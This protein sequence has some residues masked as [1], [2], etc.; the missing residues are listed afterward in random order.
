MTGST[1]LRDRDTHPDPDADEVAG[2]GPAGIPW[3]RGAVRQLLV[4]PVLVALLA[5]GAAALVVSMTSHTYAA[6]TKLLIDPSRGR[7]LTGYEDAVLSRIT[8]SQASVLESSVVL[9]PAA[10]KL[11]VAPPTLEAATSVQA[12]A[13][14]QVV[15]VTTTGHDAGAA[16]A[17]RNAVV[18]SYLKY[19]F[20]SDDPGIPTATE[21]APA[22]PAH[23]TRLAVTLRVA[24]A[25]AVLAGVATFAV[26]AVRRKVVWVP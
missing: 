26:M 18:D 5:G 21:I 20:E 7:G 8:R 1:V 3:S 10:R 22:S 12:D 11:G 24:A 4:V 9:G 23:S 25:A 17:R 16:T 14:T 2:R 6:E 19:T 15:K 13:S